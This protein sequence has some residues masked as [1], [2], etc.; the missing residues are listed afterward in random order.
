MMR[1]AILVALFLAGAVEAETLPAP[2]PAP[3]QRPPAAPGADPSTCIEWTD[4]C[5]VCRRQADGASACSTPGIAC[6]PSEPSCSQ[7][8]HGSSPKPN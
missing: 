2:A 6:T 4:G 7:R 8:L 5:I 3:A 1:V